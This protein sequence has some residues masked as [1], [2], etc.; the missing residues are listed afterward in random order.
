M[1]ALPTDRDSSGRSLG[2]EELEL[3]AEVIKSGRLFGPHGEFVSAFERG[4]SASLPTAQGVACSSGS[5]AIHAAVAALELDP[6]SEIITTPVTDMGALAPLLYQ[7][8]IPVFA[9]IDPDTGNVTASSVADRVTDRTR[10]VIVTHL[11]GNPADVEGIAA[12]VD[13]PIIEDCAQ[14]FGASI[15]GQKVGTFGDI[16]AFS[17]QQG[18][19]ITTGEGGVLVTDDDELAQRTRL[20]V[21]KSWD[22]SNPSDHNK[23]GLNYRMSELQGAVA[24][25]QVRKLDA[26]LQRRIASARRLSNRLERIPGLHA[27]PVL[28]GAHHTFWRH[29]ILVDSDVL[30]AGPD[31]VAGKLRDLDVASAPRYIKKPAF[32]TGLF[33][34]KRTFGSS[35][36]PFNLASQEAVDYRPERFPGTFRFL[37]RVLV[38]PWNE[39]L[40]E[41]NVDQIA[42]AFQSAVAELMV[43]AA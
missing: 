34:E 16:A 2:S 39:N 26:G 25:A 17:L 11:F 40:S 8:V 24:L 10:A 18:K 23:L 35:N 43:E 14:A 32:Q 22:Y 15:A 7:G 1:S 6:G 13:V 42:A 38:L 4:F 21:N 37:E 33:V 3:L 30:P 28:P 19:H 5:A 31:G 9:D 36:W 41:E 20:F 27:S 12:V 29:S